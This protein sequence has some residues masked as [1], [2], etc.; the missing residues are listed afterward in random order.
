ME[1]HLEFEESDSENAHFS[2]A[3]DGITC[4]ELSLPVGKAA[5]FA[6]IVKRGSEKDSNTFYIS[7]KIPDSQDWVLWHKRS[8]IERRELDDRRSG[9]E[10]RSEKNR[11]NRDG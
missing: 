10:R 8:S 11:R 2:V 7:G 9:S 4:G 5:K 1:I 3:V 6:E